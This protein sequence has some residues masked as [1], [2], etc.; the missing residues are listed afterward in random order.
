MEMPLNLVR[1]TS[2]REDGTYDTV[3]C[4][5]DVRV[6]RNLAYKNPEGFSGD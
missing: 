4:H 1:V 3:D 2:T 6:A 5:R